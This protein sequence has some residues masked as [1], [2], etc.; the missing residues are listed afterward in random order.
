MRNDYLD[1][2]LVVPILGL[3]RRR[4]FRG[5]F[6]ID[7]LVALPPHVREQLAHAFES[8]H[9]PLPASRI[10]PRVQVRIEGRRG[11]SPSGLAGVGSPRC[12]GRSRR[13]VVA[14][15]RPG[16]RW[17]FVPAACLVR[18]ARGGV[19]AR[20]T[21]TV[22]EQLL[23]GAVESLWVSTYAYFDGPTIFEGL[24][25]RLD[26]VPSLNVRLLLNIQ[27]GKAD[28]TS[29]DSLVRRFAEDFWGMDWPGSSRPE[30]L[31]RRPV[32]GP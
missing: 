20:D 25:R 13:G 16:H 26:A 1:R 17:Q 32:A 8:G 15:N 23:G 31:L 9:L 3:D 14:R 5:T 19:P 24:A 30:G 11:G 12:L 22:Y 21:R 27:R 6:M 29:E 7:A 18:P 28:T 2:A 10:A 4:L